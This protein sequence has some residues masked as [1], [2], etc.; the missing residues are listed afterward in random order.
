M[1]VSLDWLQ[2]YVDL[3]ASPSELA[4]ALTMAGLEVEAVTDPYRHLES[5]VVGRIIRTAAHPNA[6]KLFCC[7]VDIGSKTVQV[8]CGAPNAEAGMNAPCALPGAVLASGMS[9]EKS[10]IRGQFSEGMLCSEAE[11]ALGDDASGLMHINA[12]HAPGMPLARALGLSDTVFEFGLTPNRPDCL[13][14]IGVAR[15]ISAL[16]AKPLRVPDIAPADGPEKI[17]AHTSVNIEDPDLCPRYAAELVF[18]ISVG[19][20]PAWLQQRLRAV[21]LKPI[22]NIVDITNYVMME[23]G[24]PL[25]AFDF[26]RLEQH[27]IVVRTPGTENTFTTLDGKSREL[28]AQTLLICDGKKPV[29]IAGVM[30]GQNSEI[31]ETTTRVLIES[32]RFDPVSVRKT[33]KRLGISTDASFRFERGVDPEGTVYA[34]NR[35][36]GLMAELAGGTRVSGIIDEHPRPTP[37]KT[38]SLSCQRANRHLGTRLE[39]EEMVAYLESVAFSVTSPEPD[40]LVVTPPSFRVDVD[41]PEDIM[42]EIARLW[43]YNRIPTTFP[44]LTAR[45]EPPAQMVERKEQIRDLMAGFGF[46]ETINYAFTAAQAADRLELA[47]GDPR[48]NAENLLNPLSEEQALMRTTLMPGLL[49]TARKNISRREK[50]LKLF[51]LGKAFYKT[52]DHELP[53]EVEMLAAAW[54][55][56][57]RPAAWHTA[58]EPCDFYDIKGAFESLLLG[59]GPEKFT[60]SQMPESGCSYTR[61]GRTAQVRLADTYLGLIGEIKASVLKQFGIRQPVFVFE[62]HLEALISCLPETPEFTPIPKFPAMARDI[63][64]IVENRIEAGEILNSVR[65]M[66]TGLIEDVYLFDVYSGEPIPAGRK[67]V[68]IRVVYRSHTHTLEDTQVNEVHGQITDSLLAAFDAEL[69]T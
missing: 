50:D 12:E 47:P 69:P 10:E 37:Q 57:R 30:G 54:T 4:D 60:C 20:S 67:S 6:D 38:I 34:M 2:Q 43:G 46:Y 24:Q 49:E 42:E 17:A 58:A 11:L 14:H 7:E 61:P 8:V 44:R 15:E 62:A 23:T 3:D 41:R 59:L 5:V 39:R 53:H 16:R 35:A 45:A 64:L 21:G 13:S 28:D 63:T 22:N 29:A 1:K 26:D 55:G 56:T 19:P 27:R 65:G 9:V 51:E 18:D 68:S 48:R 31:M 66:E 25:H 32:A 52:R 33:A 36:A 40:E